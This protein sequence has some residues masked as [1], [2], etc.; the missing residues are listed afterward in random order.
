LTH[1]TKGF[2]NKGESIWL[3]S[4][5]NHKSGSRDIF[6]NIATNQLPITL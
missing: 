6:R 3:N 1:L 2:A 5:V 4:G